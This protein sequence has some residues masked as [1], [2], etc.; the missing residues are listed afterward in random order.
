MADITIA[1]TDAQMKVLR[2]FDPNKT[3]RA[4]LQAHV[5]TWLLPYVQELPV[6]DRKAVTTAYAAASPEVQADV[7]E[8]LGLG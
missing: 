7:R 6:E 5:D 3:A 2:K 1:I 8:V 4:V